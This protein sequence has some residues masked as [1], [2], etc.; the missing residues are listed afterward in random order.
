MYDEQATNNEQAASQSSGE[1]TTQKVEEWA[2]VH[3]PSTYQ[4]GR[5]GSGN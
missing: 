3:V 2:T 5:V 1:Q 4:G